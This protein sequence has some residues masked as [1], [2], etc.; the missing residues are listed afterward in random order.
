MNAATPPAFWA[1]AMTCRASVVLPEPSG[2][3]S[4]QIRPR[5]TPAPPRA[6][7]RLSAPVEMPG[8]GAIWSA[9][10]FMMLPLP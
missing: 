8:T 9:A 10:S 5:G 4:S 2:P 1:L 3:N 6:R 7:S